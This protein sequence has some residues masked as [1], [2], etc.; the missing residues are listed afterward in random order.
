MRDGKTHRRWHDV[1]IVQ[2]IRRVDQA[3]EVVRR[4]C[5]AAALLELDLPREEEW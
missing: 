4:D 3:F 2:E 5:H 1:R